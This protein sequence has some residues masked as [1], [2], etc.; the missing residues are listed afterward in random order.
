MVADAQVTKMSDTQAESVPAAGMKRTR[1]RSLLRALALPFVVLS[2]MM[3]ISLLLFFAAFLLFIAVEL[4]LALVDLIFRTHVSQGLEDKVGAFLKPISQSVSSAAIALWVQV[5]EWSDRVGLL[6]LLSTVG[7]KIKEFAAEL[8]RALILFAL[9]L[10]GGLAIYRLRANR[11]IRYALAEFS[12]AVIAMWIAIDGMKGGDLS[13]KYIVALVSGLYIMVRALQNAEEGFR[14]LAVI[15]QEKGILNGTGQAGR[16]LWRVVFYE[17]WKPGNF[18][19]IREAC[20][21]I[22]RNYKAAR[23]ERRAARKAAKEAAPE[24]HTRAQA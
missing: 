12:V 10:L 17:S 5:V 19:R 13:L 24:T 11:R 23:A 2:R 15:E 8:W 20:K 4:L 1:A 7:A 21:T 22:Y 6:T 14:D 16:E 9:F 18:A 3:I